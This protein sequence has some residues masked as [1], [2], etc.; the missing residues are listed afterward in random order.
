M[1][2]RADLLR[3]A[4][5]G[6][7]NPGRAA[8]H[9][10]QSRGREASEPSK[11][12]WSGPY[13][14]AQPSPQEPPPAEAG[15][16]APLAEGSSHRTPPPAAPP[17]VPEARPEPIASADRDRDGAISAADADTQLYDDPRRLQPAITDGLHDANADALTRRR[18]QGR[19]PGEALS[20]I[21]VQM[22]ERQAILM[23]P[24]VDV[25]EAA[26]ECAAKRQPSA[27]LS[28]KQSS[29][30]CPDCA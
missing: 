4:K 26:V 23:F 12:L 15:P 1:K 21:P 5:R 14:S 17:P 25:V 7:R 30:N 6:T 24:T 19:A 29:Q 3:Q 18:I 2:E 16:Q 27:T 9:L 28:G 11:K 20:S 8:A 10:L 13:P 22:V